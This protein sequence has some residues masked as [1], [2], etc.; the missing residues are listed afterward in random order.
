MRKRFLRPDARRPAVPRTLVAAGAAV[1]AGLLAGHLLDPRALT[2]TPWYPVLAG[3]LLAVGL[4]GSTHAIDLREVRRD[5]RALL[6]T[7]TLGVLL[8]A[9]LIAGVMVALFREPEYLVLGIA[10]AQID[11]LSVAAMTRSSRM[12]PRAKNLLSVWASFDDPVTVLLTLTT[13]VVAFRLAGREGAPAVATGEGLAAHAVT[14][15]GNLL[16]F[17]VAAGLWQVLRRGP[18]ARSERAPRPGRTDATALLLVVLVVAVAAPYMLMLAVAGLGLLVRTG[19]YAALV[20]RAVTIA[21]VLAALVLGLLLA[22]GVALG[23]GLVLGLAAFGAQ[24][25]IGLL[26]APLLFPGLGRD[27][28]VHLGIGQQNGITAVILALALEPDFPGTVAIVGP[29]VLVVNTLHYAAGGLWHA[30]GAR[31]PRPPVDDPP[32]QHQRTSRSAPGD[33][34]R[35]HPGAAAPSAPTPES[36]VPAEPPVRHDPARP[37]GDTARP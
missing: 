21:F 19:R 20:D 34:P 6:L 37:A 14:L 18:R 35:Q 28:R 7:V 17:A 36:V 9:A 32:P 31:T 8:K 11:P 4:Y 13:T 10:V 5:L 29:A 30:L 22:D 33:Q 23:P 1:A 26:I 15:G 2:A 27:D 24:A 12:S 25:V 3:L 16:L